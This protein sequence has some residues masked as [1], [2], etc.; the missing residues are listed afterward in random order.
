MPWRLRR[1]PVRGYSGWNH[2]KFGGGRQRE[3]IVTLRATLRRSALGLAGRLVAARGFSVVTLLVAAFVLDLRA[4]ATFGLYVSLVSLVWVASIG[5][6]E[7]AIVAARHERRVRD[8]VRLCVVIGASTWTVTAGLSVVAV[9]LEWVS[10]WLAAAFLAALAS[11]IALRIATCAATRAGDLPGLGRVIII[12]AAIQAAAL[13]LAVVARADGALCLALADAAGYACGAIYLTR[14][15]AGL[16]APAFAHG[17]SWRHLLAA[18]RRWRALPLLNLPGSLVALAF[19]LAPLVIVPAFADAV[20]AGAVA[21]AYR[22]FDVPTQIVTATLT[23]ILMGRFGPA[24]ETLSRA[25]LVGLAGGT[26]GLYALGGAVLAAAVPWLG[27]TG[28]AHLGPVIAPVAAFQAG[29]ALAAPIAEAASLHRDQRRLALIN[30]AGLGG[31]ALAA[32]AGF[33]SGAP[34]ALAILAAASLIRGAAIGL[35]LRALTTR[36]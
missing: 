24:R 21:L 3:K 20:T 12:Q 35:E 19:V 33:W 15:H 30:L 26:V 32:L 18:A 29:A 23:P 25:G 2:A 31:A 27:A 34:A 10:G 17:W 1:A 16:I 13:V 9:V 28:L 6:Y 5:R 36:D 8:V 11:R 14:R 7:N 22:L 4:F